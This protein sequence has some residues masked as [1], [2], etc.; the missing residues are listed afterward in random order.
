MLL[1][2]LAM[3][4]YSFRTRTSLIT[5]NFSLETND[6]IMT[7]I[8]ANEVSMT[9]WDRCRSLSSSSTWARILSNPSTSAVTWRVKRKSSLRRQPQTCPPQVDVYSG[10]QH[11]EIVSRT[12]YMKNREKYNNPFNEKKIDQTIETSSGIVQNI[13]ILAAVVSQ[14][15]YYK[16]VLFPHDDLFLLN[17]TSC[18]TYFLCSFL[19]PM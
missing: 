11:G 17:I 4:T 18:V 8:H 6:R 19:L 7:N 3:R 14:H 5:W 10:S 1:L 15:Q 12:T 2:S 13:V 16:F 9:A